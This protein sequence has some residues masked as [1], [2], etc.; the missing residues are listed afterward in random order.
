MKR[1][2]IIAITQIHNEIRKGHLQRFFEYLPKNVDEIVI[3]DDASTDGSWEYAQQFTPYVIRGNKNDFKN[4]REH[5]KIMLEKA[6]ELKAEFVLSIDA[7]EVLSD[8][9]GSK[10]QKLA[11]WVEK[12]GLDGAYLRDANLWRSVNWARTDNDFDKA[13]FLRFWK[14]KPGIMYSGIKS[15]LHMSPAPDGIKKVK[16]QDIVCFLHFGFATDKSI[17]AKYLTYAK[18]GQKGINLSRLI[19]E[20]E[21]TLRPVEENLFPKGLFEKN[22]RPEKKPLAE[23]LRLAEELKP[24]LMRPAVSIVALIYKSTDWLKFCYEQVL[25]YT[26]M[27][28]K[29]FF[30]VANDASE[31]V[32]KYLRENYIPHYLFENTD[33]HKQEWYIN[34]VYRAWNYGGSMAKGDYVLF[35]N[36]DMAFTPNWVENLLAAQNGLNCV[37]SRLVESGKLVSGREENDDPCFERNFGKFIEEFR[38]AEFVEYARN[39]SSHRVRDG[40]AFMPLLIKKE[41]F[42]K[43]GGYPEGNVLVGSDVF[44]PKIAEKGQELISGDIILMEKLKTL[45]IKHQTVYDS[46]SY[47]FQEG[48]MTSISDNKYSPKDAEVVIANNSLVGLMGEKV[49]WDFLLEG[50]PHSAGLDKKIVNADDRDFEQKAEKYISENFAKARLVIQNASYMG[51]L[52]PQVPTALIL[53]DDLR[54]MGKMSFEQENNLEQAKYLVANSFKTAASYPQFYFQIIPLGVDDNLFIPKDKEALRKKYGITGKQVGIFVGDLTQVKGWP[55]VKAIIEKHSE[56][57]FIVVAKSELTYQAS[58]VLMFNRLEQAVLS[59]LYN[60]SDFFIL[61]SKVETQCLAA[62]EACL[63]N[64]PVLMKPVGIFSDLS[65]EERLSCGVFT[66]DLEQGLIEILS[67][68]FTPRQVMQKKSLHLEGMVSKWWDLIAR[69][70]LENYRFDGNLASHKQAQY[71]N[72]WKKTIMVLRNR[73]YLNVYLR[74]TLPPGGYNFVLKL[75]R[76]RNKFK[77]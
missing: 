77:K 49:M 29:E 33:T 7:D 27:S 11:E 51:L 17:I 50:L 34:N 21:L 1:Y 67:K 5:K 39:K 72:L 37:V 4:E 73:N 9:D 10:L 41:H 18:H 57:T 19:D 47:H 8:N 25:K 28:D 58:N 23:W 12:E 24:E 38:E 35:I 75:W 66:E 13:N 3:Y 68:K 65:L 42:L 59:E 14:V 6:L 26:E 61:G 2:K 60:C 48:E 70:K 54:S 44:N 52:T 31:D 45:G 55:E 22:P 56:I 69:V 16:N 43:V 74:K 15:G 64:V 62:I 46:L 30:F 71:K 76:L 32:K 53:Q 20:S 63:C 36:S 40:G